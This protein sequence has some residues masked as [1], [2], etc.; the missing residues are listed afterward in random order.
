MDLEEDYRMQIECEHKFGL[1]KRS[2]GTFYCPVCRKEMYGFADEYPDWPQPIKLPDFGQ[3]L[4][5]R[6]APIRK[7]T[8]DKNEGTRQGRGKAS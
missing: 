4:S 2:D 6:G 7:T 3:Q 8:E 5:T 1:R